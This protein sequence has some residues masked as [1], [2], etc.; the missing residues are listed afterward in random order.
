MDVWRYSDWYGL[1][2]E[3]R[4]SHPHL[5]HWRD[6]V[7]DS[8]NAAKGYDRMVLEMLA[9]DELEPDDPDTVRAP[10]FLPRNRHILHRNV[11]P[12]RASRRPGRRDPDQTG[13]P[14]ANRLLPG[15]AIVRHRGGPGRGRSRRRPCQGGRRRVPAPFRAGG[16]GPDRRT[17]RR[18]QGGGGNRG[19]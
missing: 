11:A 9:G 4:F 13:P 7:V 16:E 1:G 12:A 17:G 8:L 14:A 6:W 15:Q 19:R 2:P 10:G 18:C 5:W 3:V